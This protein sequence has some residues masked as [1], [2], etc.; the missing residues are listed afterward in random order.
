M[1]RTML[2]RMTHRSMTIGEFHCAA[3][4]CSD[5]APKRE[6]LAQRGVTD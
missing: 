2:N 5:M 6:A 1:K 3:A 4:R